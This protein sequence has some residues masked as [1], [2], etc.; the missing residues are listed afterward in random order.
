MAALTRFG[1]RKASEIVILTF[2]T[3]HPLRLAIISVV[4]AGSAMSSPSQRRPRAIDA[5]RVARVSERIG[6]ML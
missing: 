2:R 3:L 1:A 4:D 5:I 6:R